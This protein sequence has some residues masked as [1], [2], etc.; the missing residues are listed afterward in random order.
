MKRIPVSIL[1]IA[2]AVFI[3]TF[4]AAQSPSINAIALGELQ[5]PLNGNEQHREYLGVASQSTL[6]LS[7]VHAE[8][9]IVV[10]FNTFCT[11][12]QADAAMLNMAFE[13]VE[14]DPILKG[15]IKL[16]GIAAGNTGMEVE[17]FRQNHQVPFPLFSDPDFKM[18]RAIP[19]DLRTP[20]LL[21]VNNAP[22]QELRV[23]KVHTGAVKKVEDIF[24]D[25][26]QRS[27][28]LDTPVAR[29]W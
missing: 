24:D 14:Q 15:R 13:V 1:A 25:L 23:V 7:Q 26:L 21:S 16:V 20:I 2:L 22:G 8:R 4:A 3:G 28:A 17:Q 27:A 19:K 29:K 10:V 18:D 5:F 11:I 12:C 6:S 9:L